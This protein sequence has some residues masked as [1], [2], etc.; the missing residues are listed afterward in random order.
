M[1]EEGVSAQSKEDIINS[2]LLA[3]FAA[4]A[5]IRDRA[6][7]IGWYG[8]YFSALQKLGWVM[9]SQNFQ[10]FQ[11]SGKTV[12]VHKA[13]L[14]VL[15]TVLG[16]AAAALAVVKSVLDSLSEVGSD[17]G[18]LKLFDR[19]AVSTKV[20]RFQLVT[21]QPTA[22]G[23]VNITL[24]AFSLEA[25][26]KFTQVL[27]FKLKKSDG[28]LRFAGGTAAI[29][30]QLLSSV[31]DALRHKLENV[32]ADFVALIEVPGARSSRDDLS[33]ANSQ[34]GGSGQ[35]I[36]AL[37]MTSPSIVTEFRDWAISIPGLR[38]RCDAG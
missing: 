2:T 13:I 14:G 10:E 11:Q 9:T 20:A 7:I 12:E 24:L 5:V 26:K 36:Q 1:A 3:Q 38:I 23:L 18:W 19:E 8:E 32:A 6:D 29:H 30:E 4:S 17:N 28:S 21:A 33:V 22:N 27:F 34:S 35:L 16:S 31:R 25:K 15:T 37:A